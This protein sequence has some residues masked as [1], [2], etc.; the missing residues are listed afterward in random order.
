LV[1]EFIGCV[2]PF[3]LLTAPLGDGPD[4]FTEF[5]PELRIRLPLPSLAFVMPSCARADV[6]NTTM[7]K[8]T[9]VNF[10]HCT[11]ALK[12]TLVPPI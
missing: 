3:A 1:R 8:T 5:T 11:S 9:H 10:M 7:Q 4:P 6:P 12:L 2:G